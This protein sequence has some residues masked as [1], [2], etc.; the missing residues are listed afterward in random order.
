MFE[1]LFSERG[2]SLDRLRVIVE[3]EDAGSIAQAVPGD[4][5]RQSQYSRQLRE[6]SEFFGCDLVERRGKTLKLTPAGT[7]LADLARQQFRAL[8]DFRATCRSERV[9]FTVV[10]GDSLIQWL[11]I[12]RLG[13]ITARLPQ[14]RFLTRN[15]RTNEAI[16]LLADCRADFGLVRRNA[17]IAGLKC[18]SLGALSYIAA[19]PRHLVKAKQA[20]TLRETFA[21]LPIAMQTTEG[22]FSTQLV[23]IAETMKIALRPALSCESFPQVL[24][25]VRSGRFA[26]VIPEIAMAE[27]ADGFAYEVTDSA[28]KPLDRDIVV[29]WNPRSIKIRPQAAEVLARIQATLRFR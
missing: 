6:L 24:A 15:V 25:A 22:Q 3:L 26:A 21:S 4:A 11:V 1:E 8:T 12:P 5:V 13:D 28:L 19:V 27:L 2:L 20:P 9:T 10:A 17:V 18:Q 14:V 7:M 16:R 23:K 29:A